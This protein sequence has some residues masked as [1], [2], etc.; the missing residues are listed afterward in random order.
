MSELNGLKL[1]ILV[2]FVLLISC[3]CQNVIWFDK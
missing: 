3:N 2:V 1:L